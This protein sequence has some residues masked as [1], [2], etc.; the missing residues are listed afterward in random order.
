MNE[1]LSDKSPGIKFSAVYITDYHFKSLDRHKGRP[2]EFV[3]NLTYQTALSEDNNQLICKLTVEIAPPPGEKL[4]FELSVTIQGIFE[5][6]E[7]A[8]LKLE[9]FAKL[10]APAILFPFVRETI[11]SMTSRTPYGPILL[12]PINVAAA[13]AAAKE[14]PTART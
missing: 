6:E 5:Q 2:G 7:S 9:E 10:Q 12:K 3:L 8:T 14:N 4:L 13:L 11:H 1:G